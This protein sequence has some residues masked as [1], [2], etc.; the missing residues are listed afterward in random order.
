MKT[1]TGR[2]ELFE[3]LAHLTVIVTIV[4]AILI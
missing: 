2:N 1:A 4:S 3:M